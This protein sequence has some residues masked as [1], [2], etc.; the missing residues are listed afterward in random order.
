MIGVVIEPVGDKFLSTV[1]GELLAEKDC[2][3]KK[4]RSASSVSCS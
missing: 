2:F 1:V 4:L 3:N